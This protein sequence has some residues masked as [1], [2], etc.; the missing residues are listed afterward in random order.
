MTEP[1][2]EKKADE[3]GGYMNGLQSKD[4]P[5]TDTDSSVTTVTV[6]V[7]S[8]ESVRISCP[9]NNA[10]YIVL[11]VN[12]HEELVEA[13][14]EIAK[15]AGPYSQDQLEHATNTIQAMK[16]LANEAIARAEGK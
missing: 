14:R 5:K 12:A 1:I 15:G 13:L 6:R 8:T 3:D 10:A 4:T 2:I 16:D 9:A 7:G 11:A